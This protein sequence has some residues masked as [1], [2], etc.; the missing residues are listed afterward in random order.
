[1]E[2]VGVWLS[3]RLLFVLKINNKC[4]NTSAHDKPVFVIRK[5]KIF[6]H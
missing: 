4:S 3:D 5:K 1:M 6:H 2:N